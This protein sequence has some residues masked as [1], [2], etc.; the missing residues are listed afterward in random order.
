MFNIDNGHPTSEIQRGMD[1]SP[2][3]EVLEPFFQLVRAQPLP[4]RIVTLANCHLS[5]C[6]LVGVI[7]APSLNISCRF[8]FEGTAW[9]WINPSFDLL[10]PFEEGVFRADHETSEG[11]S[12]RKFLC[13]SIAFI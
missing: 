4:P 13:L 9:C 10:C 6:A 7:P 5:A 2:L 11:F 3:E 8:T 12:R 1:P